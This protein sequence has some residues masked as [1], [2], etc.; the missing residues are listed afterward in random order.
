MNITIQPITESHI[1]AYHRVL[2][3]VCRERRYLPAT[4]AP[5][6]EQITFQITSAITDDNAQFVAIAQDPEHN[7]SHIVGWCRIIPKSEEGFTHIGN[8]SLG[9]LEKYRSRGIGRKLLQAAINHAH[10]KGLTRIQT[11]ILASNIPCIRLLE[12]FLFAHEGFKERARYIDGNY[13]SLI[14]MALIT[15]TKK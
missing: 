3:T 6:V 8:L 4:E 9:V 11:E 13:D 15:N 12:S 2:D 1:T 5:P 14:V 10:Q 7:R